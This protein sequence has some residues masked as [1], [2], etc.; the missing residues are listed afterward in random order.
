MI[1][2]SHIDTFLHLQT[3]FSVLIPPVFPGQKQG[4]HPSHSVTVFLDD[5]ISKKRLL[6]SRERGIHGSKNYRN[7]S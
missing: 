3:L 7:G 2:M 6:G 4:S 5:Y 1:C